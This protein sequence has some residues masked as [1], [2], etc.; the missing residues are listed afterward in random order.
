MG[1]EARIY[2]PPLPGTVLPLVAAPEVQQLA[3]SGWP[4]FQNL[5]RLDI[6][7]V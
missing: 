3:A 6:G 2:F 1:W 4:A 7:R 5:S